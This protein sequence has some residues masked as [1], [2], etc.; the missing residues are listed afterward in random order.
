MVRFRMLKDSIVTP[1]DQGVI[2]RSPKGGQT[3]LNIQ[4]LVNLDM[5]AQ[6]GRKGGRER[7]RDV[8]VSVCCVCVRVWRGKS[9]SALI[10]TL[11][12]LGQ[13]LRGSACRLR[14]G[15]QMIVMIM[16]LFIYYFIHLFVCLFINDEREM[17]E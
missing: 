7:C 3:L 12:S 11:V 13:V 1:R 15:M 9:E 8:C 10:T 16:C 5:K 17:H 2:L 14:D 6:R 4:I